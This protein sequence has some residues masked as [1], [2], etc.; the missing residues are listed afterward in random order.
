MAAGFDYLAQAGVRNAEAQVQD[1]RDQRNL[2]LQTALQN[3]TTPEEQQAVIHDAYA[4]DPS[5][6]KQFV[7]NLGRRMVG[8]QPQEAASPYAAPPPVTPPA[9]PDGSSGE[10]TSKQPAP[11]TKQEA[12]A[13]HA[14]RGKK[15]A[16]RDA[17]PGDHGPPDDAMGEPLIG[18]L[19]SWKRVGRAQA[20]IESDLACGDEAG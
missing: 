18:D 12:M 20:A 3:A 11:R 7:E 4:K 8:K 9:G 6:V 14:A 2:Q 10:L 13:G 15:G 1:K 19:A 5:H 16:G 17:N